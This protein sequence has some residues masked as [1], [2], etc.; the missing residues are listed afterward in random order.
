[1]KFTSLFSTMFNYKSEK[2]GAISKAHGNRPP[3]VNEFRQ[4][5]LVK[6]RKIGNKKNDNKKLFD[7]AQNLRQHFFFAPWEPVEYYA[8]KFPQGGG[9]HPP[10]PNLFLANLFSA[11][12]FDQKDFIQK[13]YPSPV[14]S[15]NTIKGL[16]SLPILA[17]VGPFLTLLM[18]KHHF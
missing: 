6:V 4:P 10:I 18:Q 8:A 13:H 1:M 16:F 11:T 12:F 2:N 15:K 17:I 14:Q 5:E 9:G 3:N 7:R